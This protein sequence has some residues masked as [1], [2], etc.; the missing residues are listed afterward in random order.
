MSQI[1]SLRKG[2]KHMIGKMRLTIL[3]CGLVMAASTFIKA[4]AEVPVVT[5]VTVTDVTTRSFCVVWASSES[6]WCDLNVFDDSDGL[7][8]TASAVVTPHPIK[9]WNTAIA[10]L[11]EDNGVMKVEVTGLDPDSTY[12]FQTVTTSKSTSD[13][14]Y[15]PDA[16]PM[17]SITTEIRV[18]RTEMAGED[19][20]PFTNDLIV[21]DCYLLDGVTPA[22]GTLLVAEVEGCDYPL[23]SF[24]GDCIPLPKAYVDLN[25]LFSAE[26]YK[27]LPLHGGEKLTLTKF[28]GIYGIE[29]E[30]Y[31]VPESGQLAE[32]K[33]PLAVWL[34]R[35]DLNGDGD[36]D[37][38]D[39]ALFTPAYAIEDLQA[40]LDDDEDVDVD[41]LAIFA[42]ELGSTDCTP[43]P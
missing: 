23:S 38:S 10:L 12:Y 3:L 13:V 42:S 36:V 34:C 26:I 1:I 19:E 18:V 17:L 39:L 16:A 25:N 6:S 41:D 43:N 33:S 11:A 8:S 14:T 30:E 4:Y 2:T 9:S 15:D 22:E 31:F 29:S 20:V 32:M 21:F 37:G 28:M 5:D 40:D 7:I 27:N 35:G 24:V